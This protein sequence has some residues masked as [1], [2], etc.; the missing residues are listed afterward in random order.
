MNNELLAQFIIEKIGG[1]GN[2][3][4][5]THCATR[6]RFSLKDES[7]AKTRELEENPKILSIVQ[8]GGQYQ[9]VIGPQVTDVYRIVDDLLGNKI[10][11]TKEDEEKNESLVGRFF[12]TLS[13]IFSPLLPA[14]A[15]SGILRGLILLATQ[16]G[17]LEKNSGTY[18]ILTVASM[19]VFYFLPIELA[20]TSAKKFGVSPFIALLIGASLINPDF[21]ALMG[22]HGNGAETT[23]IGIPVILMNYAS[24]VIPIILSIWVYSYLEKF[25]KNYIPEGMQLVF[26]PLIALVIMVPLTVI[27]IGPIG[28]YG[29]EL[30]AKFINKIFTFSPLLAGAVVGGG[31]N[32][33]VVFGLHWAVN[34]IMINNISTQGFDYLV[35]LTFATNFAMAGAT[36]GVFLKTR[37]KKL[38]A[39]SLSS[40]LTIAFAGITEPAIYGVAV[41]LKKPFIAAIIG[42]AVGGAFMGFS[43]VSSNAFVFGGLTTLPAF[44]GG[45]FIAAIIGLTICF[46]LSAILSY[47]IGFEDPVAD[48]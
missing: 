47:A 39:Y 12:S 28:V 7:I 15:G 9:I 29:G 3:K 37:N 38:K 10:S 27:V 22:T 23:F 44:V 17:I 24:T 33:L 14:F 2:I 19:S 6:L 48:I 46:I 43:H 31:W 41:K 42:G 16:F 45:N 34:P 35:P 25:L 32:V 4:S 26:V 36:F 8:K 30:I 40:V 18:T 11:S 21:I 20:I 5:V 13:A 1:H